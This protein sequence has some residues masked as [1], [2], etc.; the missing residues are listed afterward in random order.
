M[1]APAHRLAIVVALA[2]LAVVGRLSLIAIPNVSLSYLVVFVSG[3][4]YGVR[5]GAAVGVLSR[6]T[7]DLIISG[8]NPVFIP[9]AAVEGLL[10]ALAGL[11][12]RTVNVG[13]L[14]PTK[15]L[16]PRAFLLAAAILY[17][18]AFSVLADTA[19]WLFLNLFLPNAP[20]T[21]RGALLG[22]VLVRGIAFTVPAVLVNAAIFPS[23]IPPLLD[24]VR[25]AGLLAEHDPA[26]D[27]SA[28]P[29]AP[30]LEDRT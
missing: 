22:T 7:A 24:A 11:V 4:A 3:V 8:L 1:T 30:L 19:D 21:A 16:F 27:A 25:N 2:G 29:V 13:Q 20:E 17:T 14:G 18:V 15:G 10:G 6:V 9:L 26:P 5:T 12:H 28:A 23:V